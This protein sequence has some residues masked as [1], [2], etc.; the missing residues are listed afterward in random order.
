[1]TRRPRQFPK[2]KPVF[3]GC[4][5]D[6]EI[7][8]GQILGDQLRSIELPVHF[9]VVSLTPGAG[10]PLA[11]VLRALKRI[12]RYERQR[13]RF[14]LKAILMDSDQEADAPSRFELAKQIAEDNDIRI[15]W[16]EPCHEGFLLRHLPECSTRRP[17]TSVAANQALLRE[18]PDYL[19]PMT[20]TKLAGRIDSAAISQAASVEPVLAAFLRQLGFLP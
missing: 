16:Q 14:W 6:S 15:I 2:R 20:R 13:S 9:E 3:L 19:K 1:M 5:G 17:S 8:Y 12:K 7:A 11:R 10:D 4:E 18:W